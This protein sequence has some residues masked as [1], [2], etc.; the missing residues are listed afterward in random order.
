MCWCWL[1]F[2]RPLNL[3]IICPFIME[4]YSTSES[5]AFVPLSWKFIRPLNLTHCPL[6]ME[7][8]STSKS[9]TLSPYYG[10]HDTLLNL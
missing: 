1:Y 5:H 6:I 9:H 7:V 8:Y 2:N 3:T 4:V 10:R